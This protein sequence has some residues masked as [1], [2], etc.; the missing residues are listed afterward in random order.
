MQIMNVKFVKSSL[1]LALVLGLSASALASCGDTLAAMA[2]GTVAFHSQSRS[3]PSAAQSEG[4]VRDLARIVGQ[5]AVA[6]R[7]GSAL[8]SFGY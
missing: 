6:L 5:P 8:W 7:K 3:T 2:A 4:D 1:Y